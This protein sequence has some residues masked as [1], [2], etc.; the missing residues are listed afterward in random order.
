MV[1]A[2]I[3]SST[4]NLRS[5][6]CAL[7]LTLPFAVSCGDDATRGGPFDAIPIDETVVAAGLAGPVDVVRDRFGVPHIRA[8]TIED[9]AFVNG[10]VTARDR[11]LEMDLLRHFASGTVAELFGALDA[12]Q[13]DGDLEMRMHRMRPV[14]EETFAALQASSDPIDQEIV[15]VLERYADGVNQLVE[16]LAAGE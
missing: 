15:R 14:A 13:I 1:Y 16:E 6:T 8:T 7:L 4:H 9:A 12:G 10:Y 5:L 11:I 3:M 2:A